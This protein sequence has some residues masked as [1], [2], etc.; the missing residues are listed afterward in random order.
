MGKA[1]LQQ[2]AGYANCLWSPS[3]CFALSRFTIHLP[4]D[5]LNEAVATL[6]DPQISP[7]HPGFKTGR[8][9]NSK[10]RCLYL[11]WLRGGAMGQSSPNHNKSLFHGDL[12]HGRLSEVYSILCGMECAS[13]SCLL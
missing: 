3:E 4:Q 11:G 6:W 2:A 12:L 10:D 8:N 5:E 1:R 13:R 7:S 9:K